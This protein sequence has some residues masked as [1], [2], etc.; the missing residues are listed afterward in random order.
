MV[1]SALLIIGM[2]GFSLYEG[3]T[4]GFGDGLTI[5][6][7]ERDLSEVELQ[8]LDLSGL[9]DTEIKADYQTETSWLSGFIVPFFSGGI[10][11]VSW[12]FMLFNFSIYYLL[13]RVLHD[14]TSVKTFVASNVKRIYA[15][16]LIYVAWTIFTV[17]RSYWLETLVKAWDPRYRLDI[18]P[19]MHYFHLGVIV[20]IIG[21]IYRT[22][23]A[24]QKEKELTI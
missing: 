19:Q 13:Y 18:D 12:I 17:A 7:V 23:V 11:E 9:M 5:I 20:L 24:L 16:G 1:T 14:I 3:F 15:I 22:G 8:S 2:A 4:S 10:Y 21:Y 6:Q